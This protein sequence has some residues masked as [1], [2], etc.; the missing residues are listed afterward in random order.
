MFFWTACPQ[1][2]H[3]IQDV[4]K[5]NFIIWLHKTFSC[6]WFPRVSLLVTMSLASPSFNQSSSVIFGE[7]N[8]NPLQCSCLE[9]PR[10]GGAWWAAVYGVA[11]SRTRLKRLSSSVIFVPVQIT[12]DYSSPSPF[13][14]L[15]SNAHH[16][17]CRTLKHSSFASSR[18]PLSLLFIDYIISHIMGME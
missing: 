10:D 3:G 16:L 5:A 17:T 6:V 11:Q 4:S 9:Y 15:S 8:G 13:P 7:G 12:Y 14:W 2:L 1:T 18:H